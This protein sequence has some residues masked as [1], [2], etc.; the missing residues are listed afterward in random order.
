MR[1]RVT[2]DADRATDEFK[3]ARRDVNRRLREGLR[4]A[5]EQVAL[6]AAKRNAGNLKVDG[7]PVAASLTIR[8]TTRDALLTTKMIRLKARAV[9]LQEFGGVVSTVILPRRGRAVVVNGH[10]VSVVTTPRHY[11]GQKFM[12]RAVENNRDRIALRVRDEIM[13][14]FDG[15]D[16]E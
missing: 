8:A 6:P 14:A 5:G 7:Q 3:A 1:V 12:T 10:P 16:W 11:T 9:G 2:V 13:H 4:V 15:L